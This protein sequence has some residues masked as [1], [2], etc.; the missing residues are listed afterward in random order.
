MKKM[1][2]PALYLLIT[3]TNNCFFESCFRKTSNIAG[4]ASCPSLKKI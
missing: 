4:D 1:L 3:I 2:S